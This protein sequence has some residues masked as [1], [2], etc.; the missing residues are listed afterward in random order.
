MTE[1]CLRGPRSSG[2]HLWTEVCRVR[3]P[4]GLRAPVCHR[5]RRL[6]FRDRRPHRKPQRDNKGKDESESAP[7]DD[8]MNVCGRSVKWSA[9]LTPR[10]RFAQPCPEYV[11]MRR[12]TGHALE[13]AEKALG[14]A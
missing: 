3:R 7:H 5:V 11:L 6:P 13:R 10:R 2:G 9:S 14:L 4:F 12:H 1:P 8:M